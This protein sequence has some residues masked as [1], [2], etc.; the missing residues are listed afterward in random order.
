[1]HLLVCLL[2]LVVTTDKTLA[3]WQHQCDG[4]II[5]DQKP[6]DHLNLTT[7]ELSL[8]VPQTP[9]ATI[10]TWTLDIP[11]GRTLLLK[12]VWTDVGASASLRCFWREDSRVLASGEIVQLSNC[13]HANLTWTGSGRSLQALQLF[14]YVQEEQQNSTEEYTSPH[15]HSDLAAPSQAGSSYTTTTSVGV[16]EQARGHLHGGGLLWSTAPRTGLTA[17]GSGDSETL[18][19]PEEVT[20][21]GEEASGSARQNTHAHTPVLTQNTPTSPTLSSSS[22]APVTSSLASRGHQSTQWEATTSPAGT[23]DLNADPASSLGSTLPTSMGTQPP[24]APM[25]K[26]HPRVTCSHQNLSQADSSLVP[27]GTDTSFTSDSLTQ[28]PFIPSHAATTQSEQRNMNTH[29]PDATQWTSGSFW[30][31]GDSTAASGDVLTLAGSE[32][33]PQET[34]GHATTHQNQP[35]VPPSILDYTTGTPTAKEDVSHSSTTP[36]TAP[37]PNLE[38][39]STS[40]RRTLSPATIQP[41]RVYVVP[42]QPAAIGVESI[43]LLLQ[44]IL[45]EAASASGPDLEEDTRAWVEPY[46]QRAP[47]FSRMQGVW[48]SGHA[49]QILLEFDTRG[50]LQWL[51]PPGAS[52]LLEH[53]G[54][55]RAAREGRSFRW[56]KVVNITLGGVQADVCDWLLECPAGFQCASRLG[57]SNFSCSSSCHFELCRHHGICTHH[58][59]QLPV[60]RCLV[61]EDFWFMG[62]RCDVRMTRARLVG[63]CTA[64]LLI[65]AV[66]IA[67]LAFVAV[68]RYRDALIQAKVDQTRSSY[69]RF[70]HFDELS[71]R[72]WQRSAD[73]VDNPAFTRSDELLHLRALDRTCCYHDDTLSLASTCASHATRLNTIYPNSSQYAWRGSEMSVGDGVLD[74]GKASDLS[75]CSWPVEPIHWTPFP[76][77]QQLASQR[78]HPVSLREDVACCVGR[79]DD[80][81]WPVSTQVRTSRPRSYCEGMELTDLSRSWTA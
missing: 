55:A 65:M 61:G 17:A 40:T 21:N 74:S 42:D 70:N 64:I 78:T 11:P 9:Q 2:L 63:T 46:L 81:R 56:S 60:C 7:P 77:L 22:G 75:V 28:I 59:G 48:G 49:V 10:C 51:A 57:S 72:F 31:T 13:E 53:T 18:P 25:T 29:S 27:S 62:A 5:L 6:A 15:S 68:R 67:V 52:S 32:R 3:S 50:A 66:L 69:R 12:L 36:Q 35:S 73:S 26:L 43:Q 71:A 38:V 33:V 8:D 41:P 37:R 23:D 24:P 14:Y 58:P 16:T 76:L 34:P 39:Q 30:T 79:S 4:N 47:G 80:W 45:E 1:M 44:I 20:N 54:L 19:L